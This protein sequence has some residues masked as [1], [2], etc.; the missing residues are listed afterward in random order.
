MTDSATADNICA[1]L[2]WQMPAWEHLLQQLEQGRLP[3][4]LLLCGA[5]HIGKARFALALAR[6][7]L[8]EAPHDGLNCGRCHACQLS[9]S[10]NHGDLRWLAPEDKSRVIKVDAIRA[11]VEFSNRT[12]GFGLRKV[13]VLCPAESMNASAANAL[14]KSLE[15]PSA[16]T[17][18]VLVSH[19]PHG[20]PATIRSR[21]QAVRMAPPDSGQALAW[22]RQR[23][24]DPRRSEQLLQLAAGRPL[25]AQKL[26]QEQGVERLLD[27]RRVLCGL[28]D[29]SPA[30]V[31]E[32]GRVLDEEP[33]DF[34][35]AQLADLLQRVLRGIDQDMLR[36]PAGRAI[37]L[38]L[39]EILHIRRA[40]AGGS[41]PNGR[42]LL[43]A[44]VQRV[45]RE[46]GSRGLGANIY[47]A[48]QGAVP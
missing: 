26:E 48:E 39:D 32:A 31:A 30:A 17:Y 42:L 40:V 13:A 23:V 18:L 9:G 15:E 12:A 8:C 10:G 25:L 29:T 3:H 11:L 38:L 34:A 28:L 33:L 47:P 41:N 20:L 43:D 16:E 36:A 35:L 37:F 21:C 24:A 46:L 22:L 2:P 45:Q 6:L 7:L 5:T 4:A 1:P 27:I 44:L 14:L 19:R